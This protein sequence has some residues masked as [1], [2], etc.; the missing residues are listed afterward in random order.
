[1]R[2]ELYDA[3]TALNIV[4]WM[5]TPG[6]QE[7]YFRAIDMEYQWP[8]E[9]QTDINNDLM[10]YPLRTTLLP[11]PE[12]FPARM[13]VDWTPRY[14]GQDGGMQIETNRYSLD[15]KEYVLVDGELTEI[16]KDSAYSP[17]LD[18]ND[19]RIADHK[20][21]QEIQDEH[22]HPT[23]WLRLPLY[24]EQGG[25]DYGY[26]QLVE[27]IDLVQ[28][29]HIGDEYRLVVNYSP[30]FAPV[31]LTKPEWYDVIDEN[32]NHL[33][34]KERWLSLRQDGLYRIYLRPANW[35]W[36]ATVWANYIYVSFFEMFY[37]RQIFTTAWFDRPPIYPRRHDLIHTTQTA[38]YEYLNQMWSY[39]AGISW[40][41]E[42]SRGAAFL[43]H[44]IIDSQWWTQSEAFIFIGN[45]PATLAMWLWPPE[46]GDVVMGI[47]QVDNVS[48]AEQVV[49]IRQNQD[50]TNEYS[51][52]VTGSYIVPEFTVTN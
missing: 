12:P 35:R 30:I 51:R 48:G 11:W 52:T 32:G 37:T 47:G 7:A 9:R 40:G 36:V 10:N 1:M 31:D 18:I 28:N 17:I 25:K 5:N 6:M 16:P 46:A 29:Y 20:T 15:W 3:G 45:D 33:P 50:L 23:E 26:C 43:R 34:N 39:D 13:W 21:V 24:N 8:T 14:A 22:E 27:P 19:E 2:A 41:F 38:D 4:P 49:W 42:Y 44:Q